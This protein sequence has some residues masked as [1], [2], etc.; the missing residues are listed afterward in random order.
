MPRKKRSNRNKDVNFIGS[1][2]N[3]KYISRCFYYGTL[4][5]FEYVNDGLVLK[6]ACSVT[7][8]YTSST[9]IVRVYVPSDLESQII[10]NIECG[11]NYSL[12]AAPYKV[13]FARKYPYRVDLLL[14]IRPDLF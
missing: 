8:V 2:E 13:C 1:K 4:K 3:R 10:D 12:I 5:D 9:V 11:N 6:I 7:T 14:D